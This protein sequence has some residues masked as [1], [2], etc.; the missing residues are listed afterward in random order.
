VKALAG[1]LREELRISGPDAE[2]MFI[3]HRHASR[4][5]TPGMVGRELLVEVSIPAQ[6]RQVHSGVLIESF[7]AYSLR[8]S[9]A[10]TKAEVGEARRKGS[11]ASGSGPVIAQDRGPLASRGNWSDTFVSAISADGESGKDFSRCD[12]MTEAQK[13]AG[14]ERDT[15]EAARE[16]GQITYQDTALW[17]RA[18]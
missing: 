10:P 9:P 11:G 14:L 3:L 1:D 7:M 6:L 4:N 18:C 8:Q 15:L 5:Q 13:S 17:A 12:M 2:E 16:G